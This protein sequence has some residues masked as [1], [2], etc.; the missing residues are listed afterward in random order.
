MKTALIALSLFAASSSVTAA[1]AKYNFV[2]L[3]NSEQTQVCVV[4]ATQGLAAAKAFGKNLFSHDTLC[5]GKKIAEFAKQ[6]QQT[7]TPAKVKYSVVASDENVASQACAQAAAHGVDSLNLSA[8]DLRDITC[9]GRSIKS[10]A[11]SFS[12]Q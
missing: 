11:N 10:F 3:D 5:N 12:N 8:F 6:Y 1:T 2:G 4:S 7:T 9:N